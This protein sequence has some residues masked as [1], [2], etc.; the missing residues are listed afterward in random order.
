MRKKSLEITLVITSDN[1]FDVEVYETESGEHR[2][3]HCHDSGESSGI[4]NMEITSEIRS[5]VS[6]MR[7]EDED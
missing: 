7:E 2:T 5:W 3:I 1:T 4:E 6:L